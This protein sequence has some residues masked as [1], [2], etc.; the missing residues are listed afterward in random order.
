MHRK[1]IT[2]GGYLL[3]GFSGFFVLLI[4]WSLLTYSG[5]LKPFFLPSPT[6]VAASMV[7]LFVE[8]GLL[9][10]IFA[11]FYRITAGFVL[12]VIVAVPLGILV[13][14]SKPAEAYI[15]P[16][17]AFVR[18]IPP[19]AFV[20]LSILWF[21]VGDIEKVFIIF[22]GVAPYLLVLVA[23]TVANVKNEFVEAGYTLGAS[24][25]QVYTKII[26]PHSMPGIW[27][28]M[29]L[30]LGAAWTFIILAEIIAATSG[31]GHVVVQ[32]QRFLQT[33][34][35]IA[36]MI[37]IGLLGLATDYMFKVGYR[38]FFPWSEKTG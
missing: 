25:R 3:R 16:I 38:R 20:P 13:G 11:S 18:Y 23:D 2:K 17:V 9:S 12:S 14:S 27:D 21:G 31:L 5:I 33:A 36:V 32:S 10:D 24:T 1:E 28:S 34:N 19:S 6:Q 4:A 15:E 22:V 30:M 29:R 37:I 35:V 26:V 7:K 8:F